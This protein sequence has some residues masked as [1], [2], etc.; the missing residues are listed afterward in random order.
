M[1]SLIS[2]FR[3]SQPLPRRS[4]TENYQQFMGGFHWISEATV[5]LGGPRALLRDPKSLF[6]IGGDGE[7]GVCVPRQFMAFDDGE[8][9]HVAVELPA[10]R[11]ARRA[12]SSP[13]LSADRVFSRSLGW[14]MLQL[15][16]EDQLCPSGLEM[17]FSGSGCRPSHD[18]CRLNADSGRIG[19]GGEVT[20]DPM[21]SLPKFLT[22]QYRT[23]AIPHSP[24]VHSLETGSS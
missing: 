19:P 12:S 22:V 20:N 17:N 14:G 13:F 5:R 4:N 15:N 2:W 8:I 16:R 24:Q 23:V 3:T 9:A 7:S 1:E 21:V 11:D 6:V 10:W 18:V